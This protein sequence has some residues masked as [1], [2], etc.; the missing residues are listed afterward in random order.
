VTSPVVEVKNLRV[1]IA[2]SSVDIV[3]EIAFEI[4][5]GE[6]LGL[7]GESGSGKT[8]VG[9]A[10]L[11]HCRRGAVI[12]SGRISI[13]GE[14][15][16][17]LDPDARQAMRGRLVAY[18]PQDPS[19]AL[20][21]VLKVGLQL[22][23]MLTV[24]APQL[25]SARRS[26]RMKEMLE[27]VRLPADPTFLRRYP[28]QLSGG[29]QQRI[30]LAMAFS[31]R[32][33]AIVLDEPTTGLD[34][35]TQAHILRTIRGLCRNHGVAGLYVTHDLAVIGEL[36][37]RALVMYAGRIV[38]SA[39]THA[40]FRRP[41]HPYTRRLVAAVPDITGRHALVGIP[42]YAPMPSQRPQGCT[43]ASRCDLATDTCRIRFPPTSELEDRQMVRC[44]H[45]LSLAEPCLPMDREAQADPP[46]GRNV[47][48]VKR[49]TASYGATEVLHGIDIALQSRECL[50]V[51]GESGC[52][53]TTLARCIAGLHPSFT[54]A[55]TLRGRALDHRARDRA[56]D[57]RRLI[58][59]VFQ[60]PYSS[61]NPRRTIGQI[62]ARP[63]LLFHR[64]GFD[65]VR[66]RTAALLDQVALSPTYMDRYPDQLSGGER[67]RVAI[68][69][70]LAAQPIVLVCDEVTSALDVSVQA[71]IVELLRGLQQSMQLS[72]LFVTHNLA[73]IRSFAD[74]V[75]V[76]SRG[77]IVESGEV[78]DVFVAPRADYTR[79]LLASTPRLEHA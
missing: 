17:Q 77:R 74:R 6:V 36:A 54:G 43:F 55:I 26:L 39:S 48:A 33:R 24:H 41:R 46:H 63:L 15:I 28:H 70:A 49:L 23:E 60:N 79:D 7:V 72:L 58:Q 21:P 38:E 59:Y 4:N 61:L 22:E 73:L 19:T 27:E 2:G 57:D 13:G 35:T 30:A 29:Q 45:P 52:G 12:R 75:V 8:T 67:Q 47:L 10:L 14:Q 1:D 76:M 53:K 50:A 34:V 62:V 31:C 42:G 11:G 51:V 78:S 16:L 25:D 65:E 66:Y 20:N 68:A 64:L 18:I 5:E 71:T 3:D 56:A 37:H 69:R 40:L 44:W 9:L 32:P